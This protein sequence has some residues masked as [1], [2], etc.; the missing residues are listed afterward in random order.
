MKLV[1]WNIEWMNKW[2]TGNASAAWGSSSL[3][4]DDARIAAQKAAN[5]IDDLHADVLCI[6]E[7]PSHVNEMNLFI[8]EF[9]SDGAG[10]PRYEALIALD[11]RQQKMYV[12]RRVDGVVGSMDYAVDA[13][14]NSL[15]DDWQADV[16]GN[17]LLEAYDFTRVPL[18]VDVSMAGGRTLRVIV[19][20]T[21]SKYVH[22][23]ESRWNNPARRQ[24][25]IVDA[26]KARRRISAEGFRLRTYLDELLQNQMDAPFVV[27]GDFNDGPGRDFFERSYLT[28]NVTD[29]V[30]GSTFYPSLILHHPLIGNVA[31]P[32]LFTARFDDY[33][34]DIVD[35]P[36]L[37]DHILVSPALADKVTAVEIAHAEFEAEL[38]GTGAHRTQR[39]SDH[40]P[41]WIE[42]DDQF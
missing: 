25:F 19:L 21:K 14:T 13:S 36:L 39:A 23:G 6:Q 38:T 35:R 24:E 34:D 5:V 41:V 33:V 10:N 42:L 7:G 1:T 37:L 40:R 15:L 17:M 11:G 9:L 29:I 27:L 3:S 22:G 26:L 12:L 4:N 32:S 8:E 18:V 2:F 20:Y 16:D 31:P 30:L 28:H